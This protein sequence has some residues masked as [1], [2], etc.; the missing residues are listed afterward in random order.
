MP[1]VLPLRS[2]PVGLDPHNGAVAYGIGHPYRDT[3]SLS[4]R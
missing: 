3:S 4:F 1:K 2:E